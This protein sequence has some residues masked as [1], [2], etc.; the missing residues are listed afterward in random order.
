MQVLS[1][2][3]TKTKANQRNKT[4]QKA[5]IECSRIAREEF[6]VANTALDDANYIGSSLKAAIAA[7]ARRVPADG[8]AVEDA[9]ARLQELE[10]KL[11]ATLTSSLRTTRVGLQAKHGALSCFTVTLFGRT[12]AGKSTIREALTRGDGATIGK[13]AQRTTRDVREYTW[14]SLRIIDTPGI[15]AYEG[16]DDR[17]RALSVIDETDVVLFLVSSDGIQEE[18]FKGMQALRQRNRPLLFVLNVKRDVEKPVYMRRF[19]ADARSVF[20]DNEIRGHVD[21]IHRLAGEF[22]GMRD[23]RII[24]IHAQA[25]Y[26]STRPEHKEHADAL[27]EHSRLGDLLRA[28]ETEVVRRGTV[29]RVQTLVDG[30]LVSLLDLQEALAEQAKSVRRAATYLKDKFEEL[31]IWLDGFV[32]ATNS[33]AQAEASQLVQPLRASVSSFIDENIE[34]EDVGERWQR[35]VKALHIDDWLE[36][37]QSAIL[38]ELRGHLVEF[39]REMSVDSKLIGEFDAANPSQFDPWDVKR[40]LRWTSAA[41]SALAGVAAIAVYFGAANFWNPVGWIAGGASVIALGL[42]WLFDDREKKLQRQKAKAADQLRGSIDDLEH[43]VAGSLKNWFFD[44]VT[45]RLV[46]AIRNDTTELYSGMFDVA[47]ALDDGSR[48]VGTVVERLNKRLLVRTGQFMGA[49]VAED[50]VARVVRDPG[51]RAKLLWRDD[52]DDAAFCKQVG[53]AIGERVDGVREGPLAQKIAWALRPASV[54]PTKVSVSGQSATVRV[55]KDEVGRAIGRRG[56]NLSLASRLLG[57]RIK[58][59][60]EESHAHG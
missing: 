23:I 50:R 29:R 26:L 28:L 12:M 25:A 44:S 51:V 47:R 15:G 56:S 11:D 53:L 49:P 1:L 20:E 22:L 38:D 54:S 4:Y 35:K 10:A 14:N 41:G 13:G 46:R 43:R 7:V 58:L 8:A 3:R 2:A 48:Q 6:A 37:Q 40:S 36:R 30:T 57:I 34:R 24:P 55:P 33:R 59:I 19:L 42:S 45:S 16:D 21:R 17:A 5:L 18:S 27:A 9:R 52:A 31:D 39:S 60:G 32:R